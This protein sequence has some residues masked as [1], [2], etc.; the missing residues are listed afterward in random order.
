MTLPD[1]S[2]AH[3]RL[4]AFKCPACDKML[5]AEVQFKAELS[6][7]NPGQ[8]NNLNVRVSSNIVGF[9]IA[10]DCLKDMSEES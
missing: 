10:H 2:L 5:F 9:K 4:G 6:S 8:S 7:I 1:S 3:K